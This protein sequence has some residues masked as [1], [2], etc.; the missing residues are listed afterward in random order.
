MAR[1]SWL[2]YRRGAR[3]YEKEFLD[4]VA[5][6]GAEF[7]RYRQRTSVVACRKKITFMDT[8]GNVQMACLESQA[9]RLP[10]IK[11]CSIKILNRK[12]LDVP[13]FLVQERHLVDEETDG[14][15]ARC[16]TTWR[17]VVMAGRIV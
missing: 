15:V 17:V 1:G 6:A 2:R 3:R 8:V 16:V 4:D 5:V 11:Q 7:M 14:A 9:G 10:S 13:C 12:N